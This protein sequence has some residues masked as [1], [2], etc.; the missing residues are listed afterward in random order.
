MIPRPSNGYGGGPG[1]TLH[2]EPSYGELREQAAQ[3]LHRL[4][5]DLR[6]LGQRQHTG[7]AAIVAECEQVVAE[8]KAELQ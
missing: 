5:H 7:I 6:D 8:I 4:E 3:L 1:P 2:G